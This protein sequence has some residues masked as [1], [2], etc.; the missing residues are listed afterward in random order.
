MFKKIIVLFIVFSVF[1]IDTQAE[2]PATWMKR[3]KSKTTVKKMLKAQP[4]VALSQDTRQV[5]RHGIDHYD[6]VTPPRVPYKE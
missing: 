1:A 2:N 3:A 4:V 6:Q 5:R